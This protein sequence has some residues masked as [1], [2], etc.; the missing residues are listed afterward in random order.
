MIFSVS[1][2]AKNNDETCVVYYGDGVCDCS[3]FQTNNIPCIHIFA[4]I[5]LFDNI[6]FDDLPSSLL[7][8]S[9]MTLDLGIPPPV[10]VGNERPLSL[11][12]F[13]HKLDQIR[14]LTYDLGATMIEHSETMGL[15]KR[16]WIN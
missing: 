10:D 14:N 2:S 5:H 11:H 1:K 3:V 6:S 13:R 4:C 7:N 8:A 9:H 15:G 12:Q 16:C